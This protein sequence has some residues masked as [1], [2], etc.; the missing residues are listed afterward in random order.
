[1]NI[2]FIAGRFGGL[3]GVSLETD[4]WVQVLK[5]LGHRCHFCTGEILDKPGYNIITGKTYPELK[6]T[7]II[8]R[9][10]FKHPE[11]VK[12]HRL[13]FSDKEEQLKNLIESEARAI[14]KELVRW[15]EQK[16]IDLII[17]E[18]ASCFPIHIPMGVAIAR[19][20]RGEDI[21]A[22]LHHH[23]FGWERPS[24]NG[25]NKTFAAYMKYYFPFNH[26]RVRHVCIN[27][28]TKAELKKRT[29]LSSVVFPNYFHYRGMHHLKDDFNKHFREDFGLKEDEII[30]LAPV[31]VV[32]RKD[33][34]TAIKIV[35]KLDK[36][37]DKHVVLVITGF[38][39]DVGKPHE[40]NLRRL[41]EKF[42]CDVRF[43]G[44]RIKARRYI[45][46]GKRYYSVFDT[47]PYSDFVVY[48]STWEGW[49]NAFGE[50][51]AYKK[52]VVVRRYPIYRTDIEPLGFKTVSFN[53]YGKNVV[54][55]TAH[56]LNNPEEVKEMVEHNLKV[57]KNK[58]DFN[59]LEKRLK[60][61]IEKLMKPVI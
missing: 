15:V 54:N 56:Y 58:L 43:I 8:R 34:R 49:G 13:R 3:D 7:K 2:G 29:K 11:N 9:L 28:S 42:E 57:A 22:I 44:D 20:V 35:G 47:Y 55:R 18:N 38:T 51:L 23:D 31:R 14:K 41:A 45:E 25:V 36:K 6:R 10:R 27:K 30:A 16:K 12:I 60:K 61:V 46:N 24:F 5:R 4:K 19:L 48:P 52:L 59:R 33:L 17:V 37:M 40:R 26:R 21:P 32:P 1:M 39:T 50:A 53:K